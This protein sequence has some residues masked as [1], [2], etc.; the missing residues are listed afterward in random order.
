VETL[1]A[2]LGIASAIRVLR[3]GQVV[4]AFSL[5]QSKL[6]L[7]GNLTRSVAMLGFLYVL[8]TGKPLEWIAA[9]LIVSEVIAIAVVTLALKRGYRLPVRAVLN[10]LMFVSVASAVPYVA[11]QG[12]LIA[13]QLQAVVAL[14]LYGIATVGAA[15]VVFGDLRVHARRLLAR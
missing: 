13:G 8:L 11:V 5:G 12:E 3:M 9:S 7:Y 10:A 2:L 4:A 15:L 14:L 1:V 6:V